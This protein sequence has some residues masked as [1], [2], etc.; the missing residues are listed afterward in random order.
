MLQSMEN[1]GR[2][3]PNLEI[4]QPSHVLHANKTTAELVKI[5]IFQRTSFIR[6]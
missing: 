3:H 2:Y 5:L 1:E 4:I 6:H